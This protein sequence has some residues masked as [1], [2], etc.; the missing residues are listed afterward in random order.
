MGY[1]AFV[2]P[3]MQGFV[4][5]Q[6][7]AVGLEATDDSMEGL[8]LKEKDD[9][10]YVIEESR[11][12][13]HEE[14]FL[15]TLISRRSVKRSGLRYLRRGIDEEGHTANAVET[16]QIMSSVSWTTLS[17]VHSFTQVR[18]SIPLFFSQSPYSFKP[19]PVLQLS[20]ETNHSALRLHFKDLAVRY[21]R[22]QV[23]SLVNKTGGEASIGGQYEKHMHQLEEET[24]ISG[25][26][27]GFEWFDFHEKC[28]GFN[29]TNVSLLMDSLGGVLEDFGF[30]IKAD[31]VIQRRQVG[32]IRT[33]CMDCLDRTNVVQSAFGQLALQ[34]QLKDEGI[35]VNL[36]TDPSTRWL[37]TLWADNGDAISK[38]YSSTAALKGDYTRTRKRD[39]RGAIKDF[40]LT[41]SRYF[42]NIVNDYFSQAATDYLLGNVTSQ[43][44]ED[45]EANMMSGDPAMSL[46][47][48]RINAI[49]TS[50]Q[51]VIVDS[52][53][54]LLGGW[55]LMAPQQENTIR[56]FPFR[57]IVLLLT[58]SAIY[59]VRFD[60]NVE[61]V[62][63]FERIDLPS[64]TRV[65]RGT[66]ITSTLASG[67]MEEDR[68][69]G[70]VIEYRSGKKNITRSNTRSLDTA[71][72]KPGNSKE[73]A[74]QQS[75]EPSSSP[76]KS[77]LDGALALLS[78][79]NTASSL[80]ILAFK[81][82]PARSSSTG[83]ADEPG[84]LGASE[85][86]TVRSICDAIEQ[87]A[88]ALRKC[89]GA[90]AAAEDDMWDAARFVQER[91]I[92]SL[93]EAKRSTGLLEQWSYSLK[94]LV[95]A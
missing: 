6:T 39:Y 77:S 82:L 68:N 46:R 90:A 30:A 9:V 22:A 13:E 71:A 5:Q 35:E 74:K 15:M 43:V 95:W 58:N 40:G 29:F 55:V 87:A 14:S 41:L 44:F 63:S 67:Q 50:S 36:Q 38:I 85:T 26:K 16:E 20:Y 72:G 42:H 10:S 86:A 56:T 65:M 53:E 52:S 88:L 62:S 25:Q 91:D 89:G 47:K 37:N 48:V 11:N 32:V 64:I 31:D 60:W 17:K 8:P 2:L 1:H 59:T 57:E 79:R 54:D 69:V 83:V 75:G 3:L 61:M 18:G 28:R 51:I 19:V 33:N 93:A 45:F 80:K 73:T 34:K 7:F 76:T 27:I 4:G 84:P 66:Y 78:G 49:N 23:V 21:G 12:K 70:L 94:K 81:S 92:I 24:G